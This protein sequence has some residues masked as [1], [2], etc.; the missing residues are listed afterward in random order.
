[1]SREFMVMY[2]PPNA[3]RNT[4]VNRGTVASANA[5]RSFAPAGDEHAGGLRH[6]HEIGER[7]RIGAAAG[8]GAG[9]DGDLRHVPGHRDVLVEDPAVPVERG[10]PLLHPRAAG[11][12]EADDRGAR[13]AREALDADDRVGVRG[14]E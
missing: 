1:M 10:S 4:T 9:D 3:F 12:D 6:Q 8:R 7:R 2:A 11:L 13:L 14:A 5:W